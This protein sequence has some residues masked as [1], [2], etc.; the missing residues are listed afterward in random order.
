MILVTTLNLLALNTKEKLYSD[1][2]GSN[3]YIKA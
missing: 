1:M 2:N 3:N